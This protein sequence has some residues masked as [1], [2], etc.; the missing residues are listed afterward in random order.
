MQ[1]QRG[2]G[3]EGRGV[4]GVVQNHEHEVGSCRV[5]D[6]THAW[7]ALPLLESSGVPPQGQVSHKAQLVQREACARPVINTATAT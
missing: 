1:F 4:A 3:G 5:K 2:V 6:A 7:V